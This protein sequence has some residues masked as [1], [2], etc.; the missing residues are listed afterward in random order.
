MTVPKK[1]C[2]SDLFFDLKA[3][4]VGKGCPIQI[5]VVENRMK[6]TSVSTPPTTVAIPP[7]VTK[8]IAVYRITKRRLGWTSVPGKEVVAL[9]STSGRLIRDVNEL[10]SNEL[11]IASSGND[12][13]FDI[14]CVLRQQTMCVDRLFSSS[15]SLA[16]RRL[17]AVQN[18]LPLR[19]GVLVAG[20]NCEQVREVIVPVSSRGKISLLCGA[21]SV[22]LK[23]QVTRLFSLSGTEISSPKA[24]SESQLIVVSGGENF[25][26]PLIS[27]DLPWSPHDVG[28]KVERT[29][30]SKLYRIA[31]N[32]VEVDGHQSIN[33]EI[34]SWSS[35]T[36]VYNI[37]KQ[38]LMSDDVFTTFFSHSGEE[39]DIL[40]SPGGTNALAA[41]EGEAFIKPSDG[42][43]SS[44]SKLSLLL[45]EPLPVAKCP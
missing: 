2:K 6:F 41:R 22:S 15:N 9:Y 24:I 26:P 1:I 12:F 5:H 14:T 17:S 3:R 43:S 10:R 39:I 42:F 7:A 32:N 30:S 23:Q 33:I 34:P 13:S 27:K 35:L 37:V 16:L 38:S 29:T 36:D 18:A 4:S 28:V 19:V 45:D 40:N 44:G 8:L 11:Y 20:S 31:P 25:T 21:L